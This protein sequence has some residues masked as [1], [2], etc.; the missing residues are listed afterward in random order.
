MSIRPSILELKQISLTYWQP[1]HRTPSKKVVFQVTT[2]SANRLKFYMHKITKVNTKYKR[3][4]SIKPVA[5]KE[6]KSFQLAG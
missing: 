2:A 5:G 6:V 3:Q 4:L 1:G